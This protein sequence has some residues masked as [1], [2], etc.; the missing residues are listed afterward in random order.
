MRRYA[1]RL[2]KPAKAV[3]VTNMVVWGETFSNKCQNRR[4]V[5]NVDAYCVLCSGVLRAEGGCA[6]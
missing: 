5:T 3:A 6:P 1:A 4:H 2:V